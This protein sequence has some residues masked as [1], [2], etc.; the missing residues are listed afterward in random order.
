MTE[1]LLGRTRKYLLI[2]GRT[3]VKLRG[4]IWSRDFSVGV[5]NLLMISGTMRLT[6]Q[7]VPEMCVKYL[8]S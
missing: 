3:N 2:R 8:C 6:L 4:I 1:E 7:N 5:I